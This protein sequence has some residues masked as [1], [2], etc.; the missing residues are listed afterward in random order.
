[1]HRSSRDCI[2]SEVVV[3]VR[4]KMEVEGLRTCCF[5]V[6]FAILFF[7]FTVSYFWQRQPFCGAVGFRCSSFQ[8]TLKCKKQNKNTYSGFR[9]S[10]Y[11]EYQWKMY[12]FIQF[13]TFRNLWICHDDQHYQVSQQNL[14]RETADTRCS[15]NFQ[16]IPPPVLNEWPGICGFITNNAVFSGKLNYN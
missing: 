13:Q 10:T 1:M 14:P 7:F 5:S 8:S 6:A 2:V 11:G 3:A 15:W 16:C 9:K 4:E 12:I